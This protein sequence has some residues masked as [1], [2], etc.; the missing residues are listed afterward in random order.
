MINNEIFVREES[1]VLRQLTRDGSVKEHVTVSPMMRKV[2]YSRPWTA[3]G[4]EATLPTFVV[5]DLETGEKVR[6]IRPTLWLSRVISSVKWID[7][8]FLMVRGEFV[9]IFD[10][11]SGKQTHHL[12]AD[13]YFALS[14]DGRMM[15]FVRGR[16][17]RYGYKP[18]QDESDEIMLS[19]IGVELPLKEMRINAAAR[20]IYPELRP[21]G[22]TEDRWYED[23]S[24]RHQV[25]S[26][27]FWSAESREVAFVEEHR[28]GFWLVV[29]ALD[30]RG[31]E[32]GVAPRAFKLG[33][34]LGVTAV[35]WV[36]DR[37]AIRV[38]AKE[39]VYVVD[40]ERGTVQVPSR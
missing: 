6:E 36:G 31:S 34:K 28:G 32:V 20:A 19:V 40:L 9:V 15:V 35:E 17:P 27:S 3:Y 33:E 30:V 23:L 25:K 5:V 39:V 11:E 12:Y 2:V 14:P 8:R 38:R 7:E 22:E 18:P 24:E 21:W 4:M 1:G 37:R 29:L 13:A 26:G 16:L 10:V